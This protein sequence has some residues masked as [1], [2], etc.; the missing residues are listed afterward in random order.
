MAE[1]R[2]GFKLEAVPEDDER[3][4]PAESRADGFA[5]DIIALALK[6]L[7]QKSLIALASLFSLLTVASVFWLALTIA[8]N[9]SVY[10][11]ATLAIFAVFVVGIN[12]IV[13]RR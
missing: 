12:I 8:A 4:A 9:P 5:T 13:R 3:P 10:Q 7:S 1:P 2:Q 6:T 11:I